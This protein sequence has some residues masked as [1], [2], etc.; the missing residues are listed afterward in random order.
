MTM[1][2]SLSF[3]LRLAQLAITLS[4]LVGAVAAQSGR[5]WMNGFV[6]ADSDTKGLPDATAELIGDQSNE[7]ILLVTIDVSASKGKDVSFTLSFGAGRVGGEVDNSEKAEIT[8]P[9]TIDG[10]TGLNWVNTAI[11]IKAGDTVRLSAVGNVDVGGTWGVHEAEGTVKFAEQPPGY[12]PVESRTRYG[13][14][15]RVTSK[16]S[17]DQKW[18]Y[19]DARA[20]SIK[21]SGLLWLTV[22]DDAPDDNTGEFVVTITVVSSKQ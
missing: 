12:Y 6:F 15:A 3:Y 19:G 22:N 10:K 2:T 8:K 21:R 7:Q 18:A 16:G 11:E 4:I 17:P 5:S 20:M 9:I 1:K 14:A 13:I